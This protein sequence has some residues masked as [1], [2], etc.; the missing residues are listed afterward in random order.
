MSLQIV[1]LSQGMGPSGERSPVLCPC[2]CSWEGVWRPGEAE[3]KWSPFPSSTQESPH[4]QE[5]QGKREEKKTRNGRQ[6]E[7]HSSGDVSHV[8]WPQST[9]QYV[10]WGRKH[11]LR[12][13]AEGNSA[14]HRNLLGML[15]THWLHKHWAWLG[16]PCFL[17]KLGWPQLLESC[18]SHMVE[19]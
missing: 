11:G 5:Q 13:E 10:F 12:E 2:V 1:H 4:Q 16:L 19:A 15:W 17:G 3:V 7:E 14:S 9:A 8:F 18:P 6:R